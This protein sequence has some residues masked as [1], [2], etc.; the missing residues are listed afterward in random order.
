MPM[1]NEIPEYNNYLIVWVIG[2]LSQIFRLLMQ[3]NYKEIG[4]VR[5]LAGS[6]AA[7][8]A[9]VVAVNIAVGLFGVSLDVSLGIS[10]VVGWLGGNAMTA[11]A[12]TFEKKTGVQIMP[13]DAE[14]KEDNA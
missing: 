11:V 3:A 14:K 12:G 4:A 2:F 10:G 7:G 6:C 13:E 8:V 5:I 9:S 1:P